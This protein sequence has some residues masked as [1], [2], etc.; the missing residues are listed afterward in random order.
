MDNSMEWNLW[1]CIQ[2]FFNIA[3]RYGKYGMASLVRI[4]YVGVKEQPTI[5]HISNWT[6]CV[7]LL[8]LLFHFPLKRTR[9]RFGIHIFL[10][11]GLNFCEYLYRVCME[12]Y[13]MVHQVHKIYLCSYNFHLMKPSQPFFCQQQHPGD[14]AIYSRHQREHRNMFGSRV[15]TLTLCS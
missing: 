7:F 1:K 11:A 15:C 2:W 12:W 13:G 10:I 6:F 3:R 14:V 8:W 5:N 9:R 4:L